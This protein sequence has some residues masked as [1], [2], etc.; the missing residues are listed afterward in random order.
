MPGTKRPET[1]LLPCFSLPESGVP[2]P[3]RQQQVLHPPPDDRQRLYQPPLPH[4][5]SSLSPF[6]SPYLLCPLPFPSPPFLPACLPPFPQRTPFKVSFPSPPFP[7]ASSRIHHSH[8]N[9]GFRVP[10][11]ELRV[12]TAFQVETR[13]NLKKRPRRKITLYRDA[14]TLKQAMRRGISSTRSRPLTSSS[15]ST[16]PRY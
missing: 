8:F 1:W 5:A 14:G 7:G 15:A 12:H 2:L 9:F 4:R 11:R 3:R 13:P 6:L 10:G 16:P